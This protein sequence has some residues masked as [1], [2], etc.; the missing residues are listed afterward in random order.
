MFRL[1]K[2]LYFLERKVICDGNICLPIKHFINYNTC[3]GIFHLLRAI[4]T[5]VH[6]IEMS[7]LSYQRLFRN[8]QTKIST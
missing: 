8:A 1:L 4:H 2:R 6:F 7:S 5:Y 3:K